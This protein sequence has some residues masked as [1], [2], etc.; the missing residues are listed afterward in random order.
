MIYSRMDNNFELVP[1]ETQGATGWIYLYLR[2]FVGWILSFFDIYEIKEWFSHGFRAKSSWELHTTDSRQTK[3][4]SV[5]NTRI[6][7]FW[8]TSEHKGDFSRDGVICEKQFNPLSKYSEIV[9]IQFGN[10]RK[11]HFGSISMNTYPFQ[12]YNLYFR[13]WIKVILQT[14]WKWIKMFSLKLIEVMWVISSTEAFRSG[15]KC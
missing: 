12:Y 6:S 2:S 10:S 14:F 4:G 1:L 11:Y 15:S 13:P 3:P 9:L 5:L 8:S 7:A